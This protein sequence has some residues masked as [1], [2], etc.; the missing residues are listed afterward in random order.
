MEELQIEGGVEIT[1]WQYG[2]F[3]NK[4]FRKVIIV[5]VGKNVDRRLSL[6]REDR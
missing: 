4:G 6:S 3:F 2:K 5:F 1:K